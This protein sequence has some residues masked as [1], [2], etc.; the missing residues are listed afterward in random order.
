MNSPEQP[1]QNRR[2]RVFVSSIPQWRDDIKAKRDNRTIP[3]VVA[4]A[5]QIHH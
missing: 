1:N 4:W 2:I 5:L 3:F